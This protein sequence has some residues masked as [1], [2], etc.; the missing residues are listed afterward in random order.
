[1]MQHLEKILAQELSAID[2]AGVSKREEHVIT[3]V[4][5]ARADKGPR[6]FLAGHGARPFLRMNS[7]GY[8][9]MALQDDVR[10]AG[11]AA[12]RR[13]GAGPCAVRFISGTYE[14]HV[15][16]ERRLAEFHGREAGMIFS[17]A[18]STVMAV[19]P[20]LIT[21]ETAVISD[22][23][24]HNCIINATRLARPRKKAV[25]PHGDLSKL[26]E[27][28]RRVAGTCRRAIV[29]TDGVFSMRGDH[30]PLAEIGE[31]VQRY[32]P[33]FVENCILMVDDSHGVG[34]FGA[35]GRGT[36]EVTASGPVDVLVAT[37]G[38]ALGVNGGYVVGSRIL[39]DYL[40]EKATSYIYSNPIT[41]G[42]AAA[43][44]KALDVLDS[45]EGRLRLG[46]LRTLGARLREGLV[47]LGF[48]TL[49]GVHPIVPLI[50]RDT[51]R[52][53]RVV[54]QLTHSGVLATGLSFPVVPRGQEE[55]RFQVS[56]DHTQAD[57]DEVLAILAR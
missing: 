11:E 2:E 41:P 40:R 3:G 47:G 12:V 53:T 18:Y 31:L 5:P 10:S 45:E 9:G 1:M 29:V 52:T 30:A 4:A 35:T 13:F 42:E 56:A 21:E 49:P 33:R 26:D 6:Y 36:E 50:L 8:L 46:R 22:Q 32:D 48:E 16:L 24:N 17:S 34:A 15:R 19:L 20:A 27:A 28:L 51:K 23:L 43:A 25:Y 14:P 38:K 44:E 54:Q 37:L 55:V 7:N 39:I 57:I